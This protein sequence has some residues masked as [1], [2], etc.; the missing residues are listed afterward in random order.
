MDLSRY[1]QKYRAKFKGSRLFRRGVMILALSVLVLVVVGGG[2]AF[3]VMTVFR[4]SPLRYQWQLKKAGIPF[5]SETFLV[6]V[7]AGKQ[8][9]V[10]TF[11]RAGADPNTAQQDGTT[12][13]MLAS[14][15]GHQEVVK[16]LLE[17]GASLHATNRNGQ[18]ALSLSLSSHQMG[19]SS[20]LKQMGAT[21]E[22]TLL[23]AIRLGDRLTVEEILFGKQQAPGAGPEDAGRMQADFSVKDPFKQSTFKRGM[24]MRVAR[25]LANRRDGD[26]MTPLLWAVVTG[27]EAIV[28]PL[29]RAGADVNYAHPGS[30]E[31]PL[32]ICSEKGNDKIVS[33]LL[34]SKASVEARDSKG[35]TALIWATVR[36]QPQM[37]RLLVSAGA[38]IN[39]IES[40]KGMS[41]LLIAILGKNVDLAGALIDAGADVR[42]P[43]LSGR[44]ALDWAVITGHL[45]SVE[46]LFKKKE[47][48]YRSNP[49]YILTALKLAEQSRNPEIVSY[50]KRKNSR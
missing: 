10:W 21:N 48:F 24:D 25:D 6:V 8:P 34:D 11:L 42:K 29:L 1:W 3:Y 14:L 44:A 46:M 47:I 7:S 32:M 23:D 9:L 27:Q 28:E 45:P 13:L 38:D 2:A 33:L 22:I 39:A 19:L 50:L 36:N 35:R 5:D 49:A 26:G 17:N 18:S 40:Q 30:G 12:A 16:T 4:H 37:V 43:D 31:T 15:R 41:P 20:Y